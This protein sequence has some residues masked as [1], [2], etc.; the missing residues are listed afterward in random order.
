MSARTH[1]LVVTTILGAMLLTLQPMGL[2][3]E[4]PGVAKEDGDLPDLSKLH[5]FQR[6]AYLSARG[7]E[8]LWQSNR[9]DGLFVY[10]QVPALNVELEGDHYLRQVQGALALARAARFT[11][12]SRYAV[13]ARQAL[14]ALLASTQHRRQRSGHALYDASFSG[15][16][17]PG[18]GST[19]NPGHP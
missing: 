16:E 1:G 2:G 3:Q 7:A 10:G 12:T 8:W 14:L 19:A 13:R 15:S 5:P 4:R 17:S 6:V 18:C 9:P 11:N